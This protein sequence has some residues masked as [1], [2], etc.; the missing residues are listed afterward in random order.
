MNPR[1]QRQ[2]P[3]AQS[4]L[5]R[6]PEPIRT[7]GAEP[8]PPAPPPRAPAAVERPPQV[9][10]FVT[11]RRRGVAPAAATAVAFTVRFDPDE[12]YEIDALVLAMRRQLGW[13]TLDKSALFRVL[14]RI[15]RS[16]AD[17]QR[18]ALEELRRTES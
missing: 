18:M 16:S 3:G 6:Q 17:V 8:E 13:R 9:E 14:S 4:H 15:V 11:P 5:V 2:R 1:L 10:T 12:A 7:G